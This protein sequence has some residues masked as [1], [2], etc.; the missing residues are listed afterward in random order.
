MKLQK[1]FFCFFLL[2]LISACKNEKKEAL[3]EKIPTSV[4]YAQG[5]D[6]QQF[7]YYIKLTIKAPYPEA[8]ETFEYI[9]IPKGNDIQRPA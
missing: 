5:F 7:K 4:K 1:L 6:I 3:G 2:L 9:L 8:K